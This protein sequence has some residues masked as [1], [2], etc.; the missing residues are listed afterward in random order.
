M[1]QNSLKVK[2][3]DAVR[4][5]IKKALGQ[6]GFVHDGEDMYASTGDKI[7]YFKSKDGKRH[8]VIIFDS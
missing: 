3:M 4:N 7:D 5:I 2:K 8:G 6:K 1:V